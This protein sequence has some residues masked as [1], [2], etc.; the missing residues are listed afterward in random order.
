MKGKKF[1]SVFMLTLFLLPVVNLAAEKQFPPTKDKL[2]C[3]EAEVVAETVCLDIPEIETQCQ[4]QTLRLINSIKEVSKY[5]PQE[6]KLVKKPSLVKNAVLDAFVTS[7][8]CLK[9]E[10]GPLYILLLY[11]CSWGEENQ[12]CV[13][14]NREWIRIFDMEGHHLTAGLPKQGGQRR[15][16]L[17]NR[18]GISK[19]M[20]KGVSFQSLKYY[21]WK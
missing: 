14:Y 8:L 13:G 3:G 6:G 15:E 9:S 11:T 4:K 21:P 5:L 18:L 12:N 19:I 1:R 20:E 17:Y 10:S 16:K 7:W 2:V